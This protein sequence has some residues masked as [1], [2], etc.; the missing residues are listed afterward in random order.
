MTQTKPIW[1]LQ[2]QC[3]AFYGNPGAVALDPKWETTNLVKVAVPWRMVA[4][5]APNMV[6]ST[7]RVHRKCADSLK[8]ALDTIWLRAGTQAEIERLGMHLYGGGF[9]YRPKRSGTTLSM[10]AYGCA[11]DFDP[12]RNGFGDRTPNFGQPENRYVVE[13]FEAEGWVWG[14]PWSRPDGMH[15]QAA[16]V[17]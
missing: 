8:R 2:S 16:R 3:A 6:I 5:W 17:G 13:A 7:I 14:G 11:V 10:H 9:T 1:P 15:F 12:A 4:S